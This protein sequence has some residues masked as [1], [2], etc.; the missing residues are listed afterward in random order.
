MQLLPL[1][2]GRRRHEDRLPSDERGEGGGGGTISSRGTLQR[3]QQAKPLPG[4]L[5][6][7]HTACA[8][9]HGRHVSGMEGVAHDGGLVIGSH[10]HGNV[11]RPHRVPLGGGP[12]EAAAHDRRLGR[13][14]PHYVGCKV[15]RHEG[16]AGLH[17]HITRARER[18]EPVAAPQQPHT[19]RSIARWPE[20]PRLAVG[21]RRLYL[22][23]ADAGVPELALCEEG[24][25]RVDEALVAPPVDRQRRLGGGVGGGIEIRED[26]GS[27]EGVDGLLGVPDEHERRAA[28]AEGAPHDVPLH[29]V[30]V[31]KLVDEDDRVSG[32]EAP[33]RHRAAL[34]VEERVAQPDE[35]VVVGENLRG[36]F[37][38]LDLPCDRVG[39]A[40]ADGGGVA[41]IA[42][43]RHDGCG[44]VAEHLLTDAHRLGPS[45][46]QLV[47]PCPETPQVQ[48]VD[49]LL[50]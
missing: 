4:G 13:K 2:I 38:P 15:D 16:A 7:E 11:A 39:K 9:D 8:T 28:L 6:G 24:V 25:I 14:Q 5:G 32:R 21:G 1:V 19:H 48:V 45:E 43:R 12:V 37:P 47:R 17:L 31:L 3:L 41:V 49:H 26:V 44:G 35:D 27:P 34:A 40:T 42:E 22:A 29:R 30:G 18:D 23:I 46:P 20:Q 33:A 36:T 50:G 10:E